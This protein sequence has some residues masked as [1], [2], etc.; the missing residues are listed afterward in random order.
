MGVLLVTSSDEGVG[1]TAFCAGLAR[2]LSQE[3]LR[4]AL[5]KPLRITTDEAVPLPDPDAAFFARLAGSPHPD[6][7]PLSVTA[8]EARQGLQ[9]STREKITA[10]LDEVVGQADGVIVEG[11]PA[12][13]A[14]NDTLAATTQLA[15][16]LNAQV[17]G[18]LPYGPNLRVEDGVAL[19]KSV[20]ERLLGVVV[21]RVTR[22][23]HSAVRSSLVPALEAQGL[24]VLGVVPEERRM[25]G[26]SVGQLAD[27]LE[28]EFLLW[29]EKRDQLVDHVLIGGLVLELGSDYFGRSETKAVIARGDRPDTQM[30]ALGTPTRCLVLTGGHHPIQYVEYEAR[31]EEVPVVLVQGDTLTTA[32]RLDTLF[33]NT[34][35]H[36]PDKADCFAELLAESV[37]VETLKSVL[38]SN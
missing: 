19:S 28:G 15:E 4:P 10:S 22:Y 27:H 33:Q 6:S 17:V 5:F 32:K 34:V 30:A 38:A 36:H 14:P 7:W 2:L 16:S 20:G 18:L 25:L 29:E 12:V 1:R 26:V 23:R 24:K 11:P 31:E 3:Q 37:D 35:V 9:P 21:N 8:A 13:T